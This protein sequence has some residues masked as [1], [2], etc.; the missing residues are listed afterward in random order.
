MQG[1]SG[2]LDCVIAR[3]W[4]DLLPICN[5]WCTAASIVSRRS[6]HGNIRFTSDS[7][8]PIGGAKSLFYIADS[9]Q[10][11]C[12]RRHVLSEPAVSV[13]LDAQQR[14]RQNGSKSGEPAD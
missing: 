7:S 14:L 4:T 10:F 12:I 5:I 13:S 8:W 1:M 6:E 3:V 11:R 9:G 2:S